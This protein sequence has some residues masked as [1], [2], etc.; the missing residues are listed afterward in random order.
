MVLQTHPPEATLPHSS[1]SPRLNWSPHPGL[2]TESL[3]GHSALP[4]SQAGPIP[5]PFQATARQTSP[6]YQGPSRPERAATPKGRPLPH[7]ATLPPGPEETG[8]VSYCP[9]SNTTAPS[10][11]PALTPLPILPALHH[12]P[13]PFQEPPGPATSLGHAIPRVRMPTSL[14]HL[15]PG[16]QVP[17]P[18][19][20]L[21]PPACCSLKQGQRKPGI[22]IKH[23]PLAP[24]GIWEPPDLTQGGAEQTRCPAEQ[25]GNGKP[26]LPSTGYRIAMVL[27]SQPSLQ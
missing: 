15:K 2:T 8:W 16:S 22:P 3:L 5:G 24:R 7:R 17:P 18:G 26:G 21:W 9:D 14:G 6:G 11:L 19:S 27:K 4:L 23:L 12:S 10:S 13:G 1:G 25:G 20:F